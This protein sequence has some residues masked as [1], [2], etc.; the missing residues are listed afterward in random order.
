M[1]SF[2]TYLNK[3]REDRKLKVVELAKLCGFDVSTTSRWCNGKRLPTSDQVIDIIT[4]CL[5]LSY[6]ESVQLEQAYLENV[7]GPEKYGNYKII[8]ELVRFF[9]KESSFLTKRKSFTSQ[10]SIKQEALYFENCS[11]H[12]AV[13]EAMDHVIGSVGQEETLYVKITDPTLNILSLITKEILLSPKRKAKILFVFSEDDGSNASITSIL[14][15]SIV[16]IMLHCE[17]ISVSMLNEELDPFMKEENWI[18]TEKVFLRF[19]AQIQRGAITNYSAYIK[20]QQIAYEYLKK[21]SH[22][23]AQKFMSV[24]DY[25]ETFSKKDHIDSFEYMPCFTTYMNHDLLDRSFYQQLPDRDGLIQ[26]I[27]SSYHFEENKKYDVH[28][29]CSE[30]G[31]R[32]FMENGIIAIFP[33]PIYHPLSLEDRIMLLEKLIHAVDLGNCK[34]LFMKEQIL[35]NY[36][37]IQVDLYENENSPIVSLMIIEGNELNTHRL[38]FRHPS[39]VQ[40][41]RDYFEVAKHPRF[42]YTKEESREILQKV[43]EEYKDKR[44]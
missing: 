13:L 2:S 10:Q 5:Q 19:D 26:S 22:E 3:L 24:L 12:I 25:P 7:F 28:N 21:D 18:F 35:H 17:N 30:E 42:T 11:S 41:V 39:I 38:I 16:E 8:E 4:E 23:V 37:V 27:L 32:S 9:D 40:C 44:L 34:Q 36:P 6:K 33:Y 14:L 1:S 29:L 31:L 20:N 43:L 15:K